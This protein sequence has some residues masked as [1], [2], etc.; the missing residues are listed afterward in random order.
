MYI[1]ERKELTRKCKDSIIRCEN[2]DRYEPEDTY[3]DRLLMLYMEVVYYKAEWSNFCL[4]LIAV[5]DIAYFDL[6]L[7]RHH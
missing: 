3:D 5:Y 1:D 2:M 7:P 4:H 6:A